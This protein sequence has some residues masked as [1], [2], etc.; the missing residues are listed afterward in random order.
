MMKAITI[1][2]DCTSL[3]VYVSTEEC[4]R[5]I[6]RSQNTTSAVVAAAATVATK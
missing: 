4:I 3:V 2:R 5:T 1:I 6:V